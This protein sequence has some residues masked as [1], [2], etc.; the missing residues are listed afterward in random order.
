MILVDLFKR[1][2]RL[3]EERK[4]HF[5]TNHPEMENQIEKIKET[6]LNPDIII[7]SKTDSQVELFYK[8]YFVTPVTEKYMCV[9]VKV[10]SNLNDLFIITAYF[11]DSVK[12]G[13]L[14]WQKK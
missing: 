2:I 1:Q 4:K 3:T 8:H 11:T 5:E 10:S 14:I 6:L 7:K 9:V 12:K 13:E